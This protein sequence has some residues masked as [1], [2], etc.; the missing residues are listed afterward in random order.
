MRTFGQVEGVPAERLRAVLEAVEGQS[1]VSRERLA[2]RARAS[3]LSR[4]RGVLVLA[5]REHTGLGWMSIASLLGRKRQT[6]MYLA[7]RASRDAEARRQLRGVAEALVTREP[8][9]SA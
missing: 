3:E 9:R 6:V 7:E 1:G 8:S 4:G 2:S 5:L